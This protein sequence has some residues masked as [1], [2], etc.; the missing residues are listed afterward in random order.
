MATFNE[1]IAK[2]RDRLNMWLSAN[3]A[4]IGVATGIG[5]T[6][7]SIGATLGQLSS[8][9]QT[10]GWSAAIATL[11]VELGKEFVVGLVEHI[12]DDDLGE[13]D[14]A[15]IV[16]AELDK[17]LD[18]PDLRRLL[19]EVGALPVT[20]EYVLEANNAQLLESLQADLAAY[21]RI[22]SSQ[23][24]SA[25]HATL[26]PQIEE[27]SHDISHLNARSERILTILSSLVATPHLTLEPGVEPPLLVFVSSLIGELSAERQA[28]RQ[29][30][31]GLSITKPWIFEFTPATAQPLEEAYLD[32]V[33]TSDLF[34]LLI[35]ENVSPAV[36]KEFETALQHSRPI[37]VFLK[38]DKDDKD[39][40]RSSAAKTL[41]NRIPTKW[42][43]FSDPTDLA[44]KARVTITDEIIRRVRD[45]VLAL[46]HPQVQ[47]LE[48]TGNT[49]TRALSSLPPRRYTH[50]VGREEDI[51]T[52]LEKIR[53]PDPTASPVIAITGLGGIG[54]TALAYEIVERAMLERL[55]D[56]LVWE[57]AKLEELE[58]GKI[59]HLKPLAL[60]FE[61]LVSAIARQLGYDALL[62]LPSS[63]LQN[64]I[65]HILQTGS[66]LIV[67]D[68][69]ET[70]EA[71][72]ELARQ[73]HGLLSPSQSPQPS[74]ALLTSRE[75]LT[76]IPYLYDHYI[77]GLSKPASMG[78][79]EQEAH[80]RGATGI[81][82]AG[83]RLL[84][85]VFKVTYGMPLAMKLIISQFIA[86]IPLDTELDRLEEAKEEELYKFIYMRLW[87]KL[88]IPAQKVLIAAAAFASS[89]ARFMLQP[90]SK[91]TDAEFESAIPE[92][93]QMSLIEPS[94]HPTVAQRRYSIHPITH[95]FINAP[96]KELWEQQK[97]DSQAT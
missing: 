38:K 4:K 3:L 23:T 22:I 28:L 1:L 51:G 16:Q 41:I 47:R 62:Q 44:L 67:V 76:E 7:W 36:E 17:G 86:G 52:I 6:A 75:K 69:L 35:D 73:L 66:Y 68:N 70:V 54:K 92:L 82:Q 37:L 53:S 59:R 85:R 78:F 15:R 96:L 50:L 21:P 71:Y 20:L 27:L 91:T 10:I 60:S 49:L 94:D 84:D 57:N 89:V 55:F 56:G 80:D 39:A 88:S 33:R 64:R 45:G 90:V 42:A 30:I 40:H 25:V 83:Q 43:T 46:P 12:R 32:K 2:T 29:T 74:R 81:L 34:V 87:F 61:S 8:E 65:R 31:I 95:W 18:L 58:A 77:R 26:V 63:E 79:I 11:S 14:I 93:V 19:D 5:V 97:A 72:E 24:A 48:Q 9:A 13:E